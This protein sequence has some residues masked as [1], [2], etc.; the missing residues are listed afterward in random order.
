MEAEPAPA[1]ADGCDGGGGAPSGVTDDDED[2]SIEAPIAF[3]A[4]TVNVYVTPLY[5]ICM[6]VYVFK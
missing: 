2:D 3:T 5:C 4:A 1:T 6:R